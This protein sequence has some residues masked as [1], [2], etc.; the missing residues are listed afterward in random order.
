[1][2]RANKQVVN[3]FTVETCDFYYIYNSLMDKANKEDINHLTYTC[4]CRKYNLINIM[5]LQLSLSL[6]LSLSFSLILTHINSLSLSFSFYLSPSIYLY[7]NIL[8]VN[9]KYFVKISISE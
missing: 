7:L 2:D 1:M 9:R 4:H 8:K 5:V 3:L 6:F